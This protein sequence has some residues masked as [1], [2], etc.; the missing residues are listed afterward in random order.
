MS[1]DRKIKVWFNVFLF[2]LVVPVIFVQWIL[3]LCYLVWSLE[4]TE[5]FT[6]LNSPCLTLISFLLKTILS[7]VILWLLFSSCLHLSGMSLPSHLVSSFP[8]HFCNFLNMSICLDFVYSY[9]LN[10]YDRCGQS[11][12]FKGNAMLEI[13]AHKVV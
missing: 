7:D 1:W 12:P 13:V 8:F 3:M 2:I 4:W 9:I 11:L 10:M 5:P 6:T